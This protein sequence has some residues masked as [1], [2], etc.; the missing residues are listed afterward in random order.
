MTKSLSRL[1]LVAVAATVIVAVVL[2]TVLIRKADTE[3]EKVE[4]TYTEVEQRRVEEL[5]KLA[6]EYFELDT[7]EGLSVHVGITSP[8]AYKCIITSG[9]G[10]KYTLYDLLLSVEDTELILSLYQLPDSEIMLHAT[11]YIGSSQAYST[12]M[13]RTKLSKLFNKNYKL[14]E[15]SSMKTDYSEEET[16]AGKKRM[17]ER[18]KIMEGKE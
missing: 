2:F 5:R 14:G 12:D 6:P 9:A 18:L 16:A 8:D 11:R 17:Q 3:E 15:D 10:N 1:I 13:I 7:S 4:N